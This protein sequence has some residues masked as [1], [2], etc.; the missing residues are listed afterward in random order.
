MSLP[1]TAPTTLPIL[2]NKGGIGK[3]TTAV[4]LASALA[5][6]GETVL[7]IDLDSQASAAL[8]LGLSRDQLSPSIADVLFGDADIE[9]TIRTLDDEPVDLLPASLDLAN[10]DV[11]LFDADDRHHRLARVLDGVEPLYDFII[12]DCPPATSLL[13]LNA[14]VAADALIIPV[15]PAYLALE[16]VVRLGEVIKQARAGLNETTPVLGLLLT[17]VNRESENTDAVISKV[18]NHYGEKVFST[19]IRHDDALA[20]AAEQGHSVFGQ[21]SSRTGADDYAALAREVY[22][23]AEQH[24]VA[25]STPAVSSR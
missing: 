21:S 14:I 7:L 23:R 12:L 20:R 5:R 6:A 17:M 9:D 24:R 10:A 13:T 19:E 1:D 4:N 15:S 25:P 8:S 16:G 3:T 2:N 18:R 11:S 22:E